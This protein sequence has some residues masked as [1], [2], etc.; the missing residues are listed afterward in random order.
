MCSTWEGG[1]GANACFVTEPE[2]LIAEFSVLPND[3]P[4]VEREARI[5]EWLERDDEIAEDQAGLFFSSTEFFELPESE[6][7]KPTWSTRLGSV[8]RWIQSP[9]EAPTEGWAF[10]GQLDSTYSFLSAPK[11]STPGVVEDAEKFEGR[12]HYCE[13][14]NLGDGGIAYLFLR[15]TKETPEGWFFWQCG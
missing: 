9:D 2:D 4:V 1:S 6:A 13:G 15:K 12:S 14:P 5:V 7:A 11:S 10:F 3:S 8:P